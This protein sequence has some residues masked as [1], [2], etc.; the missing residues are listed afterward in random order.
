MQR[1]V[2]SVAKDDRL[3]MQKRWTDCVE[4]VRRKGWNPVSIEQLLEVARR[5]NAYWV[6]NEDDLLL[7]A[8][9]SLEQLQQSI[10][11]SP[12]GD[13]LDFWEYKRR[14]GRLSQHKPKS[15]IDV[16]RKVYAWL[17]ERLGTQHGAI[18][19]R[20]VAIHWDQRRTDIEIVVAA[21]AQQRRPELAV[22]LEVKLAWNRGVRVDA[23]RQ[24]R[25]RYLK[26]TCRRRGIYIV[27]W[28]ECDVWRPARRAL[29]ARTV[30]NAKQ[31][32]ATICRQANKTPIIITP[33]VLDC[34]LPT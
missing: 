27:A 15:E 8:L 9:E 28:F 31:E 23:T 20:E 34:S 6:E 14:G 24:L 18:I 2:S 12:S 5:R 13:V 25:D 30:V 3:W 33:Y 10:R 16:A 7:V 17:L 29:R 19:H 11:N 21:N 4:L 32:V 22:V 26:R 1:I